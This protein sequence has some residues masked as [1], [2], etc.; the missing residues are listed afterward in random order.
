MRPHNSSVNFTLGKEG[1]VGDDRLKPKLIQRMC[2]YM[3]GI[4]LPVSFGNEGLDGAV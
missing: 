3:D 4:V 2:K 1:R